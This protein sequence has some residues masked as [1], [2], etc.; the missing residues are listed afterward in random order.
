M[1]PSTQIAGELRKNT[2]AV[3]V[4]FE[5][6]NNSKS[7]N[8]E[9]KAVIAKCFSANKR[10]LSASKKLFD[11]KHPAISRVKAI[12]GQVKSFWEASTLPYTEDS[13]RLL[14]RTKVEAFDQQMKD[15]DTSLDEAKN[16]LDDCRDE[17]LDAAQ[18]HHEGLGLLWDPNDYPKV[19]SEEVGFKH[20]YPSIEP[21]QYLAELAPN[22][23]KQEQDRIQARLQEAVSMAETAFLNEFKEL[24]AHLHERLTP[25]AD[26]KKKIFRDTAITNLKEFFTKFKELHLGSNDELEK[27]V[28]DAQELVT[29]IAPDELREHKLLSQQIA[30]GLADIDKKLT[31]LV[32]N[33]PRRKIIKPKGPSNVPPQ[34]TP[35]GEPVPPAAVP[36]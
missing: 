5:R 13:I 17:I 7:L 26:G 32:V 25:D 2:L 31:P 14:P 22:I 3:R 24:V 8:S 16:H 18:K 23:Y 36:A 15:Y 30:Q 19:L 12:L 21:P 34:T 4:Q 11:I 6:L 27:L 28:A 10:R 33:Q 35:A 1:K 20:D 9:Q 29:G